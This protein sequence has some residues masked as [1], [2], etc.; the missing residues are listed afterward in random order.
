MGSLI[1]GAVRVIA[2][3]VDGSNACWIGPQTEVKYTKSLSVNNKSGSL[4]TIEA[5]PVDPK[6]WETFYGTMS[7]GLLWPGLHGM[8]SQVQANYRGLV[9]QDNLSVKRSCIAYRRVAQQAAGVVG[10][11]L[12]KPEASILWVH[13][14]QCIPVGGFVQSPSAKIFTLHTP[15]PSIDHLIRLEQ[16]LSPEYVAQWME[17][18]VKDLLA[19]NAVTVHT[20]Q[21]AAHLVSAIAR[22]GNQPTINFDN[23]IYVVNDK[24]AISN[25]TIGVDADDINSTALGE[26]HKSEIDRI[27]E[28]FGK[29]KIFISFSRLDYTKGFDVLLEA[30]ENLHQ[31]DPSFQANTGF[32]VIAEPTRPGVIGYDGYAQKCNQAAERITKKLPDGYFKMIKT[33]LP[34]DLIFEMIARPEITGIIANPLVDGHNLTAREFVAANSRGNSKVVI[35]SEAA[36]SSQILCDE[37]RGGYVLRTPRDPAE[38]ARVITLAIKASPEE[39]VARMEFMGARSNSMNGAAFREEVLAVLEDG[40]ECQRRIATSLEATR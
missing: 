5:F 18:S 27:L 25:C 13:D 6:D 24:T 7:N 40:L 16:A 33:G 19:Y 1:G 10:S 11:H 23:G 2:D 4:I 20:K 26:Q 36:G 37:G 21:D 22:Y 3:A 14:Y 8:V 34:Q 30:I 12:E 9:E 39:R 31:Q 17:K 35:I 29:R 32:L 28:G 15:F 38:L